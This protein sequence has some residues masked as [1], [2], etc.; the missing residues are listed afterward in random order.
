MGEQPIRPSRGQRME[1]FRRIQ[2]PI[3]VWVLAA[4]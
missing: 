4:G 3:L 1:D 2:A